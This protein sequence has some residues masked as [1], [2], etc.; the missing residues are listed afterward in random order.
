MKTL[1]KLLM[2]LLSA[3]LIFTSCK[4]E[5]DGFPKKDPK[6][7]KL[8]P[9]EHKKNLESSAITLINETQGLLDVKAA[10]AADNMMAISGGSVFKKEITKNLF[11]QMVA[12]V[13]DGNKGLYLDKSLKNQ[14]GEIQDGFDQI[15]GIYTW[16]ST[17]EEFDFEESNNFVV[18][19]PYSSSSTT[20]DCEMTMN[21][22]VAAVSAE[23]T[24]VDEL[25]S[26]VTCS[27]KIQGKEEASFL[28]TGKYDAK[29]LPTDLQST[30][31]IGTYK[32]QYTVSRSNSSISMDFLYANG[33]KTLVNY[34]GQVG[35]NLNYDDIKAYAESLDMEEYEAGTIAKGGSYIQNV[36]MYFQVVDIKM[37]ETANTKD[38]LKAIDPIMVKV[39]NGEYTEDQMVEKIVPALNSNVNL[40]LMHVEDF[41]KI[42]DAQFFVDVYENTY[43]DMQWNDQTEMYD[44]VPVTE[45]RK[46]PNIQFVFKDGSKTS[47]EAYFE[48]GFDD[49]NKEM[50][51]M[52]REFQNTF[53]NY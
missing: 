47:V 10:K 12:S 13:N 21:L 35:G 8:S 3:G 33:S 7:S 50:E 15:K 48:K 14:K 22:E 37:V 51:E 46:Q 4:K 42:A 31:K 39:N 41:R 30:L 27:L 18:K 40:Y 9:E 19:F 52:A 49:V 44:Y 24:G 16:N 28:L 38:L 25:P 34:G 1:T 5:E 32:W 23:I 26:K 29:G 6:F 36:K 53:G 11:I 45:T 20:N 17:A 2:V 43:Y